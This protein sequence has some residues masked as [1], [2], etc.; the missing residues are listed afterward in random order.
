MLYL[1][2]QNCFLCCT[3]I[4]GVDNSDIIIITFCAK[5]DPGGRVNY[6]QQVESEFN[7]CGCQG[8]Y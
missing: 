8:C 1:A 6:Q 7:Y 5:A 4:V 3:D 2:S